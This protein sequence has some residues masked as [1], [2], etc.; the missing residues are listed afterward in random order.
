MTA[1]GYEYIADTST[2]KQEIFFPYLNND[3]YEGEIKIWCG[4]ILLVSGYY[5]LS[6]EDTGLKKCI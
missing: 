3:K 4:Q 6:E 2:K 1:K 5:W